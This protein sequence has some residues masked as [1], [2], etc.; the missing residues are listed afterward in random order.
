[1]RAADPRRGLS[2]IWQG[3]VARIPPHG[4][5]APAAA[6]PA[7]C[8]VS[9]RAHPSAAAGAALRIERR[10][11]RGGGWARLRRPGRAVPEGDAKLSRQPPRSRPGVTH[12]LQ[13]D[14][15]LPLAG[16]NDDAGDIA[17]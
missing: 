10:K 3:W 4:T 11:R 7:L 14:E 5:G 17:D 16:I 8:R 6:T 12:P 2:A 13:V 15:C 9:D 1:P